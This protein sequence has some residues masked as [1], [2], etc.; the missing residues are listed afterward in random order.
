MSQ[1]LPEDEP[2]GGGWGGRHKTLVITIKKGCEG[3]SAGA[4][5]KTSTPKYI[6]SVKGGLR[7]MLFI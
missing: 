3:G 1:C 5:E 2:G 7:E 6:F 4:R